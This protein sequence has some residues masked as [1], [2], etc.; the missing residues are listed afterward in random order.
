[1]RRLKKIMMFFL[2]NK[3]K[4]KEGNEMIIC[5]KRIM[6]V[7]VSILIVSAL[8]MG[9]NLITATGAFAKP[10]KPLAKNIIVMISDGWGFYHLEAA[11][12]YEY[13]KDARQIYNRFPFNYAMST[14]MAYYENEVCYGNWYDPDLAWFDFEYVKAC[15]TDS[16]AAATA[17]S[18]GVK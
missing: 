1:M 2:N 4:N 9:F 7:I 10:K 6:K 3:I 15:A 14:Y 17:M 12:Y 8:A 13:G 5:R 16:A 11:S 18:T